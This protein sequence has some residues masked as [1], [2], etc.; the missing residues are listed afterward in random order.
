MMKS[1]ILPLALWFCGKG[2]VKL[3]V[4]WARCC[5]VTNTATAFH[6]QRDAVGDVM[7]SEVSAQDAKNFISL[8]G[9]QH[10]TEQGQQVLGW[11]MLCE[12]QSDRLDTA[13]KNCSFH[14][15]FQLL[16]ILS[17]HLCSTAVPV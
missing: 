13:G 14:R 7:L 17:L 2:G 11:E 3:H 6:L 5:S 12:T 1:P 9:D 15:I 4:H 16:D 8:A 10:L